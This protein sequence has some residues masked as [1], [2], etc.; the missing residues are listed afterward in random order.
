MEKKSEKEPLYGYPR[1]SPE[2]AKTSVAIIEAICGQ[3]NITPFTAKYALKMA[4][5]IIE[6]E[7][8][9]DTIS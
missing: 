6:D 5:E 8:Q 7:A 1:K 9:H 4:A 3:E 2:I